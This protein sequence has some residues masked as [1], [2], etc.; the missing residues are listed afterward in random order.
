MQE[1]A[2]SLQS[3][4]KHRQFGYNCKERKEERNEAR[5]WLSARVGDKWSDVWADICNPPKDK[6]KIFNYIRES[7]NKGWL[8]HLNCFKKDDGGIYSNSRYGEERVDKEIVYW[9]CGI[10]TLYV[11]NN[12]LYKSVQE[13]YIRSKEEK[14]ISFNNNVYAQKDGIWFRVILK[15]VLYN[16]YVLRF[17]YDTLRKKFFSHSDGY[18]YYGECVYCCQHFPLK[19]KEL[20]ELKKFL[21]TKGL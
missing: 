8:V 3:M 21:K 6:E 20:K 2:P 5:R 13:K 7:V 12:I 4:S 14:T 9:K 11:Y 10:C 16:P 18:K 17:S 15:P 1:D 19:A